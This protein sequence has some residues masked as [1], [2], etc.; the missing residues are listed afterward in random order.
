MKVLFVASF[1]PIVN[2][3]AAARRFFV[4]AL[5][6]PLEGEDYIFS[7]K[8]S[9]AKHFGVWPLEQ[10]AEA[11]FGTKAWPAG[12]PTPQASVEFEVGDVAAAAAELEER[13]YAL[14]HP[15][16]TEP[17]NQTIARVQTP[18]GLLVGVCYTPT[19]HN[20]EAE[21]GQN[22]FSGTDGGEAP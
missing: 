2:D 5:G 13:G 7:E 6:L 4:D 20:S 10:A 16:R 9:G 12:I 8:L 17:W 15:T 3:H 1:S 19:L 11:C 21:A 22:P 14:V 18:D